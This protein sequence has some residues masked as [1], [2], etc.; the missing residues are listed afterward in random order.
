MKTKKDEIVRCLRCNKLMKEYE[1][2]LYVCYNC[3][4]NE[5]LSLREG[6]PI[7]QFVTK[8]L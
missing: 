2:N 4:D 5:I 7:K 1:S 6:N 8:R 3:L